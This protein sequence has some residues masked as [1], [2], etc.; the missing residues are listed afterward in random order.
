MRESVCLPSGVDVL[1]SLP[2]TLSLPSAGS[3]TT[4][5]TPKLLCF[6]FVFYS[7]LSNICNHWCHLL[8]PLTRSTPLL[9]TRFNSETQAKIKRKRME[10]SFSGCAFYYSSLYKMW[11]LCDYSHIYGSAGRPRGREGGERC[12]SAQTAS[13]ANVQRGEKYKMQNKT[14]H[15]HRK[16]T[17]TYACHK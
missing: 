1:F 16:R 5:L 9:P 8:L 11:H 10:Q 7:V 17:K 13:R 12:K 3:L 6:C 14:K 15:T 2:I 4:P